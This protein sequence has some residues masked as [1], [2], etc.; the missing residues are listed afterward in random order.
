MDD[1]TSTGVSSPPPG[2]PPGLL[3]ANH[4][5]SGARYGRGGL[6]F[7]EIPA[8]EFHAAAA[9]LGDVGHGLTAITHPRQRAGTFQA[10]LR[11]AL[12]GFE[13]DLRGAV[14]LPTG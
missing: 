11:A 2:A 6:K 7:F 9:E 4:P 13:P 1:S 10:L 14:L 12:F 8:N 3:L 5:R